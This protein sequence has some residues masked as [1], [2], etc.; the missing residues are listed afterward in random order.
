MCAIELPFDVTDEIADDFDLLHIAIGK[1]HAVKFIFNQYHQ[2]DLIEP[3]EVPEDPCGSV[4]LARHG[5][6]LRILRNCRSLKRS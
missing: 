4:S 2:L 5:G 1:F 6:L 3:V